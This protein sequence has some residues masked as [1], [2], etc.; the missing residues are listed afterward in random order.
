[1]PRPFTP[2][3]VQPGQLL[4][5]GDIFL[6]RN[7]GLFAA[8][9]RWGTRTGRGGINHAGIVVIDQESPGGP[10]RTVEAVASGVV[11]SVRAELTG[12]VIRLTD[13]RGETD[14]L[15]EAARSFLGTPY[16]WVGIG[17]FAVVCLRARWWGKPVARLL[18]LALPKTD[19]GTRVFCSDHISQTLTK[20]YG[21]LG[22]GPKHIHGSNPIH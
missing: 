5:A 14:R 10:V 6:S 11:E 9:I 15:V 20:V 21:D 12:Y 22:L 7:D 1:M 13:D 17:R 16:D 3:A 19:D 8:L 18:A 2:Q 4:R